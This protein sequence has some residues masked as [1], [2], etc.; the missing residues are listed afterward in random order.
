[1][2]GGEGCMADHRDCLG[3]SDHPH[4]SFN[5]QRAWLSCNE[6]DSSSSSECSSDSGSDGDDDSDME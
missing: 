2:G 3:G 6:E 4:S 5:F 1:M